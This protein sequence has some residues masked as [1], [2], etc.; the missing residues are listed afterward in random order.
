MRFGPTSPLLQYFCSDCGLLLK[1]TETELKH[2]QLGRRGGGGGKEE[3]CPKCGSL[4]SHTLQQRRTRKREGHASLVT[5]REEEDFNDIQPSQSSSFIPRFQAAY[6]EYD[7]NSSIIEFGFDI[8]KIDS[9]LNLKGGEILCIIGEQKYTQLFVARLCV[10]ALMMQQ[11]RR[12][13]LGVVGGEK[14]PSTEKHIIFI[15]AGNDLDVYQYVNF[16]RQYGLD[17]KKFLQSIVSSRM[18]TIYQ[19]AN[20]IICDLPKLIIQHLQRQQHQHFEPSMVIVGFISIGHVSNMIL[21]LAH[22]PLPSLVSYFLVVVV[23]GGYS[24]PCLLHTSVI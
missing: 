15:D 24:R 4:L 21:I 19:L 20:T 17:I 3:E 16:A 10:N 18:F 5:E 22:D 11:R 7:N 13:R 23:S 12:R 6:E 1:Q 8:H 14:R 2:A 9:F